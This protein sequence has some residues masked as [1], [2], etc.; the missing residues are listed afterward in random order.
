MNF[1]Y[2]SWWVYLTPAYIKNT[3]FYH[4]LKVYLQRKRD[5]PAGLQRRVLS[6]V[7]FHI[8]SV[9]EQIFINLPLRSASRLECFEFEWRPF[10]RCCPS[11]ATEHDLPYIH[12]HCW[13]LLQK[14]HNFDLV[15]IRSCFI[16]H[17][18]D[19]PFSIHIFAKKTLK[20]V[21]VVIV[22]TILMNICH[23]KKGYNTYNSKPDWFCL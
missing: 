8:V 2:S 13:R 11:V 7:V 22:M 14:K 18:S 21:V 9:F 15:W 3:L 12:L 5:W 20:M 17:L 1:T 19:P 6:P 23:F 4:C 10:C 16:V